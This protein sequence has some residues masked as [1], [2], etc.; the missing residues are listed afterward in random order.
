ML[1]RIP[2]ATITL[3]VGTWLLVGSLMGSQLRPLEL[4]LKAPLH[5]VVLGPL[6][7]LPNP[8]AACT[9]IAGLACVT[10]AYLAW[11]R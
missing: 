8:V 5:W 11:R 6:S 4:L 3:V 1:I 2:A 7:L 9:F 10:A